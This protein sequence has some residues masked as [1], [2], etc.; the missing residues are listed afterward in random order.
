MS[1]NERFAELSAQFDIM[2]EE[3][4]NLSG[5]VEQ[6]GADIE[7]LQA[8]I[9]T[10]FTQEPDDVAHSTVREYAD[11]IA[12]RLINSGTTFSVSEG[13]AVSHDDSENNY[14]LYLDSNYGEIP[15]E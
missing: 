4:E 2:S 14:T 3:F 8:Q 12:G 10:G 15:E 13:I 9:G 7:N 6:Y 11:Y 1:L 5:T